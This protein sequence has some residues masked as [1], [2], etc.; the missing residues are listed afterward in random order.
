ML[1]FEGEAIQGV[2]GILGK[3]SSFGTIKH[4]IKSLDFQ[5]SVNNGIVAFATG[6]LYID[7]GDNPVKFA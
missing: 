1:T 6:D 7:G 3:L 5:P 4:V 2:E